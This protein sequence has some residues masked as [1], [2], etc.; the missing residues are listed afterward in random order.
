VVS[1]HWSHQSAGISGGRDSAV[2][3]AKGCGFCAWYSII[4]RCGSVS[5]CKK[6]A[7][8]PTIGITKNDKSMRHDHRILSVGS[9]TCTGDCRGKLDGNLSNT[10]VPERDR[11]VGSQLLFWP[12]IGLLLDEFQELIGEIYGLYILLAN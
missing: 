8:M 11:R 5:P 3:S 7:A 4:R 9:D 6:D 1:T 2:W 12:T 10:N